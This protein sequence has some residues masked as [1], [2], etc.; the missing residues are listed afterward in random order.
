MKIFWL[1]SCVQLKINS[2]F[3]LKSKISFYYK[4]NNNNLRIGA[5]TNPLKK[6]A[7]KEQKIDNKM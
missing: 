7:N 1:R 5:N 2:N 6:Q 4:N 3:N